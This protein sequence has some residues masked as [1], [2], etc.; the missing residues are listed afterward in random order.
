[1][2][3]LDGK[4]ELMD[5]T[6]IACESSATVGGDVLDLGVAYD[7]WGQE[8]TPDIGEG[9]DLYLNARIATTLVIT[10][11]NNND[12]TAYTTGSWPI[13]SYNNPTFFLSTHTA[14]TSV[15]E[16]G[17]TLIVKPF[18]LTNATSVAGTSFLRQKVPAGQIKRYLQAVIKAGTTTIVTGALDVW[19]GLDSESDLPVT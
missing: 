18:A 8:I 11:T 15:L 7:A 16:N 12:T 10:T 17:V 9:G 3:I 13:G 4:L 14:P 19:L 1:M 5:A 2:A 6:S